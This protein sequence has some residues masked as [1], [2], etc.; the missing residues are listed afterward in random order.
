MRRKAVCLF[1][2]AEELNQLN[3]AFTRPSAFA[4]S[5][6]AAVFAIFVLIKF[7]YK[8]YWLCVCGC[9]GNERTTALLTFDSAEDERNYQFAI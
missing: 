9:P 5:Q 3:G 8:F 7:E 2:Q 6:V 1:Y 4:E